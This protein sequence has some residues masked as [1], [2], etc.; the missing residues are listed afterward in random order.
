[1]QGQLTSL[2]D[3]AIR[4]G[5]TEAVLSKQVNPNFL[6]LA[7]INAE[8]GRPVPPLAAPFVR[9][10]LLRGVIKLGHENNAQAAVETL[11]EAHAL[12]KALI[13]DSSAIGHLLKLGAS[14]ET[15]IVAL[16][17]SAGDVQRAA[18]EILDQVRSG[19]DGL[20]LCGACI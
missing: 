20:C 7:I 4:I 9:L 17:R 6:K 13:V 3:A 2:P 14:E 15:A 1:M 5:R 16:R 18:G 12:C 10:L 19:G 11:Q 8:E